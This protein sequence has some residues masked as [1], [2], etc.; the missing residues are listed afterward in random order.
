MRQVVQ[1]LEADLN[2]YIKAGQVKITDGAL[3]FSN[4]NNLQIKKFI[5]D[6]GYE[7]P[8]VINFGSGLPMVSIGLDQFLDKK[9]NQA[10]A[11]KMRTLLEALLVGKYRLERWSLGKRSV[12]YIFTKD[13]QQFK[14]VS[15]QG[16][17]PVFVMRAW[18]KQRI[19]ID[20]ISMPGIADLQ[21]YFADWDPMGFI[22]DLEAPRDEYD[23]EAREVA[24]RCTAD[25]STEEVS[26]IMYNVFAEYMDVDSYAFR[27]E[28]HKH[29]PAILRIL[30]SRTNDKHP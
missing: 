5:L 6:D 8:L 9:G 24:L 16:F 15:R 3:T 27:E 22:G 20:E 18:G 29:A 2:Q 4:S 11:Q 26:E 10:T 13:D 17:I 30:H 25:M 14:D 21:D 28:C 7:D 1:I 23:T 12:Y 19:L